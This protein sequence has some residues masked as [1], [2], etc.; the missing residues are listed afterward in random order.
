VILKV[1]QV[2]QN[3]FVLQVEFYKVEST[4]MQPLAIASHVAAC[5]NA[6]FQPQ[7]LPLPLLQ[8]LL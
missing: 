3:G 2:F 6:N 8:R 1:V 7:A 5:I 4:V